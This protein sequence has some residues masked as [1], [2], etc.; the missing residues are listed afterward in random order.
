MKPSIK[1][2]IIT[3]FWKQNSWHSHWVLVHTLKVTWWVIK[4][5]N[6]RMFSAWLLHDVWKPFKS[7]RDDTK[8]LSY[9]FHWHEEESY[10]MIKNWPLIS[11]Y[12]KNLVRRHYLIRGIKKA[13]E[14]SLDKNRTDEE[15]EHWNKENLRQREVWKNLDE[16]F[17]NDLEIFLSY[18]DYGK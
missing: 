10:Q 8:E 5:R 3:I 15:R 6:F 4:D 17:K 18:D 16:K 2:I 7:T 9:S 13:K 1:Q 12:T 14:K 11:D